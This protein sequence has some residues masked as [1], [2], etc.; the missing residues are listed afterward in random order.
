LRYMTPTQLHKPNSAMLAQ[1]SYAFMMPPDSGGHSTRPSLQPTSSAPL[2]HA[3]AIS[4]RR[5]G[6]QSSP[7]GAHDTIAAVRQVNE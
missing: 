2:Q 5:I 6:A 4:P 7:A 3:R 1:S